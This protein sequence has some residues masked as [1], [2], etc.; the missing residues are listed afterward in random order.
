MSY[1]AFRI[2]II[3]LEFLRECLSLNAVCLF[4]SYIC[5]HLFMVAFPDTST[6]RIELKMDFILMAFVC[7]KNVVYLNQRL[8]DR[9]ELS[10]RKWAINL[11]Y[12]AL[13]LIKTVALLELHLY[14]SSSFDSFVSVS[15]AW[16]LY[17]V[18]DKLNDSA[19]LNTVR[20]FAF[21]A[22]FTNN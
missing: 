19:S 9:P 13:L 4:M 16:L 6:E 11:V 20:V 18:S 12:L 7:Y 8:S 21:L 1:K 17:M 15:A 3:K 5:K 2:R 22:I 14:S 10:A